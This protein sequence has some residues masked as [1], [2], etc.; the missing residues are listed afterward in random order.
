MNID[1]ISDKSANFKGKFIFAENLTPKEI[2][3]VNR[4]NN[5]VLG[6]ET[7]TQILSKKS[8][9]IFVKK[10]DANLIELSTYYKD[11][12]TGDKTDC[13]ISFIHKKSSNNISDIHSFRNSLPWFEDFKKLNMG[14]NSWAEK[15]MCFFKDF[16]S[17]FYYF[18][19]S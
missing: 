5:M 12:F 4:V 7:N 2:K 8:Y 14:Y 16:F 1:K 9:D 6:N 15:T 13:F 11:F 19:N 17:I 3:L 18:F 10:N